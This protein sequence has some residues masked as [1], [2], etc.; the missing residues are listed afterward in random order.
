MIQE[1]LAPG[2][3][4]NGERLN[5]AFGLHINDYRGLRSIRHGGGWAGYRAELIRFPDQKF[6]VI[7]LANLGSIDT[8]RLTQKIADLY[9]ADQFTEQ[10]NLW[11]QETTEYIE[12]S[13]NQI[14]SITGFYCNQKTG[15]ML[16][17]STCDGKLRGETFGFRFQL[18]ATNPTHLKA[19]GAPLDIQMDFEEPHSESALAVNVKIGAISPN[20]YQKIE[21]TP[22]VPSQLVN[23][24][25]DY[26][27]D[28]LNT[29]Y[30]FLLE[31]E[32]L[33]LR[34]GYL[35][36]A[37]LRPITQ[38]FFTTYGMFF[39]FKRGEQNQVFAF[40]LRTIWIRGIQ[41]AKKSH[42]FN[43]GV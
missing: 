38:D 37:A 19:I 39:Q 18:V 12:L 43:T 4:N 34:R 41:F 6:S 30:N 35:P 8:S 16:E 42:V 26:H 25:G 36:P 13:A 11:R 29:T 2:Y 21:A 14:K 7:C 27:S 9:L 28:E 5:Y 17:L 1:V 31:G 32:Q 33:F 24:P 20:L 22:V 3:L 23:L 10:E 40:T 15:G